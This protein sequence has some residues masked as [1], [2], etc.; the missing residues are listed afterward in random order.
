[1]ERLCVF[2]GSCPGY[3]KAYR[4]AAEELGAALCARDIASVYGG[5]KLGPMGSVAQEVLNNGGRA[6]GVIPKVPLERE[7]ALDAR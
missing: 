7:Q 5:S 4:L 6:I 3:N 2:C 1:M